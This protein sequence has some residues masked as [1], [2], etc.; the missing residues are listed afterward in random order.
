[1]T[2]RSRTADPPR[3]SPGTRPILAQRAILIAFGLGAV[4]IVAWAVI[5][6]FALGRH[7][8]LTVP[9]SAIAAWGLFIL[10][11]IAAWNLLAVIFGW[12]LLQ[13]F[14]AQNFDQAHLPA[15]W[16]GRVLLFL[17]EKRY[18]IPPV[19]FLVGLLLGRLIWS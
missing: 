15:G 16:R 17:Y 11:V 12:P 4:S 5:T 10:A 8:P 2:A 13:P 14:S 9:I 19:A 3:A 7:L 6:T 18:R 1:M